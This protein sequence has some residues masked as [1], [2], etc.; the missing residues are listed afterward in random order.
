MTH[1]ATQAATLE[2][3]KQEP[4]L[5]PVPMDAAEPYEPLTTPLE[6]DVFSNGRLEEHESSPC[7]SG[8]RHRLLLLLMVGSPAF[9]E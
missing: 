3:K 7:C 6:E 5:L 1:E 4:P 2:A 9:A 8:E